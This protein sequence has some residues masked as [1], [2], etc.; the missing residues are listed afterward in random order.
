MKKI[1]ISGGES[2]FSGEIQKQNK[3]YEIFALKRSEMDITKMDEIERAIHRFSPDY[4]IHTA[5]LSRPMVLHKESPHVS[6]ESNIIGTSNCVIACMKNNVKL[7][8]IST[9]YVYPGEDGDYSETSPLN[10]VNEY[11]W[12]KLGGECAVKLYENSLIVRT[13]MT[14][15]PYPH[16]KAIVDIRKSLIPYNDAAGILLKVLDQKGI[17]NIGCEGDTIFNHVKKY[18]DQVQPISLSEISDVNMAKDSTMNID[19][20]NRILSRA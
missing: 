11:A 10:P 13:A 16:K 5:A 6:I 15:V 3:D 8:Y 19:K 2:K 20:L 18:D 4:F 1:L 14:E 9:D 7:I 17:L 12:S